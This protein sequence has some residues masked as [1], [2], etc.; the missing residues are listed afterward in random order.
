MH[1]NFSE[2]Q[3]AKILFCIPSFTV[4]QKNKPLWN[5]TTFQMLPIHIISIK[6]V[7]LQLIFLKGEKNYTVS[8]AYYYEL[9]TFMYANNFTIPEN[10]IGWLF[11]W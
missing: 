8:E 4:F 10:S 9:Q 3:S 5:L 7:K 11:L 1:T 6:I 2:S